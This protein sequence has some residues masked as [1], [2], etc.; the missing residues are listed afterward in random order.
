[1]YAQL[2]A[3]HPWQ[4]VYTSR[5]VDLCSQVTMRLVMV[6][7]VVTRSYP[8]TPNYLTIYDNMNRWVMLRLL[9]IHVMNEHPTRHAVYQMI[10]TNLFIC[11]VFR[12][13]GRVEA[14]QQH[15]P[16][17]QV[18]ISPRAISNGSVYGNRPYVSVC[19]LYTMA[20]SLFTVISGVAMGLSAT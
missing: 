8:H 4:L 17:S 19:V 3:L 9:L 10:Q 13:G 2:I 12:D 5:Y 6:P 1:M 11:K 16:L 15:V 14:S 20:D 7:I 18:Q